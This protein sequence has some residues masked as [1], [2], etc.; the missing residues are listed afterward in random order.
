MLG[1]AYVTVVEYA[2]TQLQGGMAALVRAL[3]EGPHRA[4]AGQSFVATNWYDALP[5]RPITELLAKLE[6]R[7]WEA[8]VRERA[9]RA[10]QRELGLI[11]RVR[12]LGSSSDRAI[13][14]LQRITTDSFDFGET[15][16]SQAEGA[17][18]RIVFRNV[19]QP[20]GSWVLVS[21]QAHANVLLT[22]AGGK[23]V[24]AGGRLIPTGRHEQLGLVEVRLDLNWI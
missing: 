17:R 15:E 7:D 14:K 20:L 2:D 16:L 4:F 22:A 6:G 13:E 18:A 23:Q 8:T 19:P 1:S 12:M 21:L 10:A 5:I 11:N 3:P 9:Q 24:E